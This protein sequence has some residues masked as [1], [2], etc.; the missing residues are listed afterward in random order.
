MSCSRKSGQ[1]NITRGLA[2]SALA[3][4]D[5]V[6]SVEA[7]G[8]NTYDNA[9]SNAAIGG[10]ATHAASSAAEVLVD[11]LS[12]GDEVWITITSGTMS[13]AY[14][15]KYADLADETG[16]TLTASANDFRIKGWDGKT[17]NL[18]YGVF[19]TTEQNIT[20]ANV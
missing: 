1:R 4:G 5:V 14:I 16:I 8:S 19:M 20:T 2:G 11:V 6:Q 15:G 13:D 9:A 12:P 18:C 3:K 17:T 10:I 7:T